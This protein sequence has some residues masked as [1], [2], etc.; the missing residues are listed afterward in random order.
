MKKQYV[1]PQT[2]VYEMTCRNNLLLVVS[3]KTNE[4]SAD[5]PTLNDDEL[6]Q[7]F[8]IK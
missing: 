5:A 7:L 8:L 2:D 1:S 4:G 3:G 6:F